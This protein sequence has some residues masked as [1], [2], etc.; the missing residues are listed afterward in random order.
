M[1]QWVSRTCWQ[2]CSWMTLCSGSMIAICNRITT[3]YPRNWITAMSPRHWITAMS[4]RHL[5]TTM[6]PSHWMTAM[7]PRHLITTTRKKRQCQLIPKWPHAELPNLGICLAMNFVQSMFSFH[8]WCSNIT[9]VILD[10]I[11]FLIA[12]FSCFLWNLTPVHLSSAVF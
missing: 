12:I 1:S 9:G 4:P 3:M 10:F 11:T 6:Y 2:F 7:Y 8:H 5:I